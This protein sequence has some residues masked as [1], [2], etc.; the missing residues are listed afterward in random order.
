M[1]RWQAVEPGTTGGGSARGRA[2]G[3]FP[4]CGAGP[5]LAATAD[6]QTHGIARLNLAEVTASSR[7]SDSLSACSKASA[8]PSAWP[9]L[10]GSSEG[11]PMKRQRS[12]ARSAQNAGPHVRSKTVVSALAQLVGRRRTLKGSD[13]SVLR[14]DMRS[15]NAPS[16]I[17]RAVR[18]PNLLP[19]R[20]A[21]R[22]RQ[23]PAEAKCGPAYLVQAASRTL[24]RRW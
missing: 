19:G 3:A 7:S 15:R 4:A 9:R 14:S 8:P 13:Q 22:D 17:H 23:E 5:G 1:P 24:P 2:E 16:R 21:V 11:E 6:S 10:A 20:R 12:R 18:T